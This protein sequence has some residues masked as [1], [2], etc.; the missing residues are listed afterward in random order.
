MGL[1]VGGCVVNLWH[2]M[3]WCGVVRRGVEWCGVTS[4]G[5]DSSE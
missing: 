5:V 2:D 1:G 4:R 3:V